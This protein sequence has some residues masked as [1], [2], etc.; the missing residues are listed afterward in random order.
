LAELGLEQITNMQVE[1]NR[2]IAISILSEIDHLLQQ[3]CDFEPRVKPLANYFLTQKL[4]IGPVGFEKVLDLTRQCFND[5]QTI[6][7][8]YALPVEWD[9][10]LSR[11]DLSWK[12]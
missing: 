11:K 4:R 5:L 6:T 1:K 10:T 8:V 9:E 12:S 3:I 7:R 2:A